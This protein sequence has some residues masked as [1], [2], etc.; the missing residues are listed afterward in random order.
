MDTCLHPALE[1]RKPDGTATSRL[2]LYVLVHQGFWPKRQNSGVL[3][4]VRLHWN[5]RGITTPVAPLPDYLYVALRH[6]SG[7]E[8]RG[9][10][11]SKSNCP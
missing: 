3:Q 7:N 5:R 8:Y 11:R 6:R 9:L 4:L 2:R 10:W 1:L